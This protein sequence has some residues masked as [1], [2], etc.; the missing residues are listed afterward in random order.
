[1]WVF[2]RNYLRRP[3]FEMSL[4]SVHID[5]KTKRCE[6]LRN[7]LH[8]P[9][10]EYEQSAKFLFAIVV[11][12]YVNTGSSISLFCLISLFEKTWNTLPKGIV[13][14]WSIKKR[15]WSYKILVWNKFMICSIYIVWW[16]S[17]FLFLFGVDLIW[18]SKT[19]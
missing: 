16:R 4:G 10:F 9:I 8:R 17:Q 13:F 6:F 2:E 1:M 12:I 5:Y 14:I 11:K 7:S 18:C 19:R 15:F 3:I